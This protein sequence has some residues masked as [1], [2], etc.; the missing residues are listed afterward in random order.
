M[1]ANEIAAILLV[2]FMMNSCVLSSGWRW[3]A[4]RTFRATTTPSR[5]A[6]AVQRAL[7][8]GGPHVFSRG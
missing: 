7:R 3:C 8:P 5:T 6:A 1:L 2:F 4:A